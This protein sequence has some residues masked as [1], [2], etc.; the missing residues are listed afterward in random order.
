MNKN[1][2][3]PVLLLVFHL[4]TAYSQHNGYTQAGINKQV[5]QKQEL[6]EM[7]TLRSFPNKA[8]QNCYALPF[9]AQTQRVLVRAGFYYG[10]YDGL[11]KPPSFDIHINGRNWSTVNTSTVV[12]GP[13]YHEAMYANQGAGSLNVC[14]VQDESGVVPFISSIEVVPIWILTGPLYPE[15]ETNYAYNLVSRINF[16]GEEVRFPGGEE[17]Y[18][19]VWTRG[20]TPPNCT[21]VATLPAFLPIPENDPPNSVLSDSIESMNPADPITLSIDLPQTTPQ[22]AYLVLYFTETIYINGQMKSTVTTENIE[23]K[24]I[25]IYP[26]T[27]VGPTINVTLASANGS[28]LPPIISAM[29]VF[30]RIE[31]NKDDK[32][33]SPPSS[34]SSHGTQGHFFYAYINSISCICLL[35]LFIA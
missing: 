28:T 19:R 16:G 1:L 18:N 4:F 14:I 29:E 3:A 33:S 11:S 22:S 7:N 34:T 15:M 2:W 32:S 9:S 10:N 31:A 27:V 23:C 21:E 24:V 6:E 13:I 20:T 26:V 5:P 8:Q 12:E 35:L 17:M 25:T 30:T